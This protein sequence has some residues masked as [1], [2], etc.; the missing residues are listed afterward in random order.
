MVATSAA[1]GG[2]LNLV[3]SLAIE[4][5]PR[6]VRVNSVLIGLVESGQW[7]RRFEQRTDRAQSWEAWSGALAEAKGIP[8][9]RL[10]RPEEAAHAIVFLASPLAAYT[11]GST[12]DVSGGH[13]HHV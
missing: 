1:R 8:L 9:A 2:V 10:G 13:S 3:H 12:I 7:R 11:T 4:L 5:A 6:R